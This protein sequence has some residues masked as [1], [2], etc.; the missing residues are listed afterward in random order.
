MNRYYLY[1]IQNDE[2]VLETNHKVYSVLEDCI[3]NEDMLFT[4]CEIY[5]G[6]CEFEIID[7]YY[8]LANLNLPIDRIYKIIEIGVDL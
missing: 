2:R 8:Q 3:F 5:D 1:D 6:P 7:L 4:L